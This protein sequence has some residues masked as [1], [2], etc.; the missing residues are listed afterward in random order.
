MIAGVSSYAFGWGVAHGTPRV[1]EHVLL[2]FTKRHGLGVVQIADNVPVGEFSSGRLQRMTEAA[3]TA[4]VGIEIG[5]R[6]LTEQALALYLERCRACESRLLRFVVDAPSYEPAPA[7]VIALV[8]NAVR[9]LED[10]DV[11]LAIENHDRIGARTLRDMID[12]IGSAHVGICLDTANS[13]G[14]GEGLAWITDLLAPVTVNL[15]VKDVTIR[16]VPHLMGFT[17]EG[18][19]LG[20][21]SLPIAETLERVARAGRCRTVVLETWTTPRATMQETLAREQHAAEVGATRLRAM[22]APG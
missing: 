14:A 11:T 9:A 19:P 21:G 17:I 5:A 18:S 15:H 2:A 7:D 3:R 20:D 22:V 12:R 8:R 4:G 1:D 6:G 10:A 13:L 16:R